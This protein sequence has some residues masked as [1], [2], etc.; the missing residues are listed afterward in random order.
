MKPT[1]GFKLSLGFLVMLLLVIASGAAGF[2][3][4]R[5]MRRLTSALAGKHDQSRVIWMIKIAVIEASAALENAAEIETEG[6][7]ATAQFWYSELERR[8]EYYHSRPIEG[9]AELSQRLETSHLEFDDLYKEY[10]GKLQAREPVSQEELKERMDEVVRDYTTVL[11]DLQ[12]EVDKSMGS[13]LEEAGRIQ[14]RT[15]FLMAGFTIVAAIL[16]VALAW[17]VIRSVTGPVRR[18]VEVADHISM[19]DLD[20]SIKVTSRDEIGEL[21]ESIE[22]MRV[23]LK[24]AIERLKKQR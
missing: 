5:T 17:W 15:L 4:V 12:S 22:R 21:Q 16:G 7:I 10:R 6:E 23:S 1:I 9:K 18:L 8:A 2:T 3:T 20:M 13:A 14:T 24:T 19:G 11:D